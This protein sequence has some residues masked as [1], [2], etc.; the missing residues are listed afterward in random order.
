MKEVKTQKRYKCDFCKKRG[1]KRKM[2]FHEQNCYRNP[3]RIC[4]ACN[5][6]GK[7]EEVVEEWN[8]GFLVDVKKLT[9]CPY[10]KAFD[11]KKKA[12]IEKYEAEK[13]PPIET[14]TSKE[15]VPF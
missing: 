7:I 3:S 14:I 1:I 12:E 6:S 11:P 4:S 10:C 9:D 2:E 15:E 13:N 5:N 8:G